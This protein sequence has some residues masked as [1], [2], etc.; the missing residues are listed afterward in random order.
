MSTITKRYAESVSLQFNPDRPRKR[1][2]WLEEGKTL[3]SVSSVKDKVIAK[4]LTWWAAKCASQYILD[5]VKP[6]D[7][8][9]EVQINALVAGSLNAHVAIRD[10]SADTGSFVHDWLHK[11]VRGNVGPLPT[12][13]A[14]H[15]AC[16]QGAEWYMSHKIELVM[17]EEPLCSISMLMAGTPD[18]ICYLDGK[19][20]IVDWK[21]GS[22]LYYDSLIQMAFYALF[23]EEEFGIKVEQFVLVNASIKSP[24]KVFS[25]TR[26]AKLKG[27]AKAVHRLYKSMQVFE[28]GLEKGGNM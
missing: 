11:M 16:R 3:R 12:N 6:G 13:K 27:D 21:T 1:Y 24:F 5:N 28:R 19:L 22:G 9:D 2:V 7:V 25:T 8:L 14:M 4:N 18:L 10:S 23:F 17:A 15:E 26:V 20:T